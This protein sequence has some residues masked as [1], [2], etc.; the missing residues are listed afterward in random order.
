MNIP[1]VEVSLTRLLLSTRTLGLAAIG[2][3]AGAGVLTGSELYL[4]LQAAGA[5]LAHG[6]LYFWP[7]VLGLI[8]LA[9]DV[10]A[11]GVA[12]IGGGLMLLKRRTGRRLVVAALAAGIAG[13]SVLAFVNRGQFT[14]TTSAIWIGLL[15]GAY[16]LLI[17]SAIVQ[18]RR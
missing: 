9:L 18:R 11:A 4:A 13:E 8:G 12:V 6:D 3:A 15:V 14:Q 5:L 10:G 2:L 17:V 1:F 16:I 7:V